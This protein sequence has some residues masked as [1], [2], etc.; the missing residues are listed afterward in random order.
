MV[1][2]TYKSGVTQ[3]EKNRVTLVAYLSDPENE[4]PK[5]QEYSTGILGYKTQTQLYKYYTTDELAEIEA[6][7]ME[8]RK[9]R[10]SR[11]RSVLY[12]SL[13][14]EGKDGNVQAIK[15]FL[16]RTEG[17]VPDKVDANINGNVKI[18]VRHRG[19]D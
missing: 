17:K 10:S 15:E 6:E 5:R 1:E 14:N 16:D 13:Y 9:K 4:W 7:A 19:L 8:N 3:K 2:K 18:I 12:R 11:Q